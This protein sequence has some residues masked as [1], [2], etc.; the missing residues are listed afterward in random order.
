VGVPLPYSMPPTT[1]APVPMMGAA[2]SAFYGAPQPV[3]A[4][5]GQTEIPTFHPSLVLVQQP[6]PIPGA[7]QPTTGT[8]AQPQHYYHA[9]MPYQLLLA[10]PM[11]S[12]DGLVYAPGVPYAFPAAAPPSHPPYWHPSPPSSTGFDEHPTQSSHHGNSPYED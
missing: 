3:P 8:S 9:W 12:P 1:G 11:N 10:Q 2:P 7:E 4:D 5:A 6:L